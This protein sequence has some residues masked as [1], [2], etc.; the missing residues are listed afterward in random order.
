MELR[1]F[2]VDPERESVTEKCREIEARGTGDRDII[3]GFIIDATFT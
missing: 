3:N 2:P 1:E